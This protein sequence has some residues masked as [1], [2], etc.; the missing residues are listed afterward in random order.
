M[1]AIKIDIYYKGDLRK[2]RICL[3]E[4]DYTMFMNWYGFEPDNKNILVKKRTD[5][6]DFEYFYPK[7]TLHGKEKDDKNL[8]IEMIVVNKNWKI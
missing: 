8:E 5:K 7:T 6:P 1:K 3:N 4:E 2:S